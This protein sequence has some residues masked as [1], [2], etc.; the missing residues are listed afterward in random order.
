MNKATFTRFLDEVTVA[1][2]DFATQHVTNDLPD[3]SRYYVYLNQSFDGNSH[4]PGE[5]IYSDDCRARQ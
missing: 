5:Q 3:S 1:A 4:K 2:R